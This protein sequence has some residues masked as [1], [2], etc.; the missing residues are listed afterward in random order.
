MPKPAKPPFFDGKDTSVA[1]VKAWIFSVREY[2]E[3]SEIEEGK[4]TRYAAGYLTDTAKTWYINTYA[5]VTPLPDL[6][7]FLNEFKRFYLKTSN[8]NDAADHIESI[9]QGKMSVSEYSTEFKMHLSEL[10]T[11]TDPR[12]VKRHFLRGLRPKLHI[13]LAPHIADVN[14]LNRLITMAQDTHDALALAGAY[15]QFT[16]RTISS[17]LSGGSQPRTSGSNTT[18]RSSTPA[19]STSGTSRKPITDSERA[20]LRA[21]NGCFWCRKINAGHMSNSCPE[22]L[23]WKAAK[24]K[25]SGVEKAKATVSEIAVVSSESDSESDYPVPSIVLETEIQG[26]IAE[27]SLIDCGATV[28]LVDSNFVRNRHLRTYTSHPIRIHQAL[29]PKG[30]IVNTALLSKIRIPSKN[31][32]SIKPAKFIVTPLEHHNVILG[33]PFL[34]A[35]RI[36]ID[37]AAGDILPP[38]PFECNAVS[39][40]RLGEERIDERD[41]SRKV[42]PPRDLSEVSR[43][44]VQTKLPSMKSVDEDKPTISL[45]EATELNARFMK[46]YSDVFTNKLPNKPTHPKAPRH[47]IIL[48][49]PNKS[50][51]G[52]LFSLPE[53]YLNSMLDFI[54]EQLE[55]KRIRPS[56]SNMAA[57]TWMIPKKDLNVMPRV[58]HDYR[59]LNENT[60]KDHTPL[61]RQEDIIR[62][63]A[64]A[65]IRGKLDMPMSYYQIG[66]HP[67]DVY[68]TAFK[69]PFGMFEW[70]VMPQGLCNA[71]ATFQRYLNWVLR[72]YVGRFCAVYIDDIAIWSNSIEE[73]IEHVRLILDALREHGIWVSK[74]K[75]IL[76]ADALPF[77]GFIVSSKGVEV[78]QD[79]I[80]KI[81]S[82]HVPKSSHDIKAFNGL[83]NYIGQFIP[84]LSHWSTVL[85]ALTRKNTIFKWESH[86]QEAFDNIKRLT[87]STPICKP[88][89]RSSTD[90]VMVVADASNRAIGGYY[91]Q[92][93]DYKTMQPAGFH[94]RALKPA[95]KNYPTHDKEMLAIV[96][97]LKRWEPQ[98]SGLHFEV[99]TDHAPLTHWKTQRDLSPRQ[100]RWNETLSRFDFDIHHIPGIA[101]SAADA[102]SRYP[103]T[104]LG[105]VSAITSIAIDA[106]ILQSVK[107]AYVD[108]KL[109]GPVISNPEHYPAYT[110]VDEALYFED[111]LCIPISDRKTRETLLLLHH[112]V[113]NH[114]GRRKTR[115]SI[116]REYFWPGLDQDVEEYIRTCDSCARNKTSTQAPA[117]LLHPLPVPSS[118]FDELAL[119]FVGPLPESGGFDMILGMTDRLTNYT[120]LEPVHSTAT[121]EDIADV[122]YRSW[123]RQFGMPKAITS[124][125]DKLFT[126]KFWKELFKKSK[127]Q[128]RMS[129][130]YHP[131]TDGA[132]ERSN[133]TLIEALRHYVNVRQSDW[134]KHLMH[135]EIVMNN[136]VNTTTGKAPNELLYGTTVRLFPAIN[137]SSTNVPAVAN[138][139][140][141]VQESIAIARDNHTV[142][143]TKQTTNANKHRREE[144]DYKVGDQVYLNTKN[145]RLLIKRKGRSAKFYPRYVGPFPIIK[146]KPETST[147]KLRLPREYK[148]HPTFHAKLLKPAFQNDPLLFSKRHVT[149]PPPIDADNDEW[150]VECLLD[151]RKYRRQNQFLVR[152]VGYP[153]Y[154]DSWE[155]EHNVSDDLKVE[156]WQIIGKEE[157]QELKN[158]K[159]TGRSNITKNHPRGG[160]SA[161]TRMT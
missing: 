64:R 18:M 109:F 74:D 6:D 53:R 128:L 65:K 73:H 111:R 123:C 98:L 46:E 20:Y 30:F 69:T 126:S 132:S 115:S 151:H 142:A 141:K 8:E 41:G 155:P 103:Y 11:G 138:Y 67:D 81:L 136:S 32:E 86:H 25:A 93:K 89:N 129:T 146:A 57:G 107:K 124:D 62:P 148:I 14:D 156:Y 63:M 47:R 68:K 39:T 23:T 54:D 118:R 10:G 71:P 144:P 94:S 159:C 2:V 88:I 15:D 101:N 22:F 82:A 160:R 85:S 96:D 27:D 114:F 37:P 84:A 19:A 26:S 24:D 36:R 43:P 17:S 33:M 75:S 92:G 110:L 147:Y 105:T 139:I 152:W 83:V 154:P 79:K 76:F 106:A 158:K 121:A 5:S 102:L 4:Q 38:A 134:A 3:L 113:E 143:K 44:L 97:C 35:E 9:K 120:K 72:K 95:E 133:K 49:D 28:N 13:A 50:I 70:L 16:S 108:D 127:V 130:A 149:P 145:L 12:W 135:V 51:N 61:P 40:Q 55:A 42:L 34:A 58:V 21:N 140:E 117:G 52:R 153:K 131:E 122:V 91:G 137:P 80:D 45:S 60:V 66:M 90:S 125:R 112:D 87:E 119:D 99:L 59:Q 104:Q 1:T 31:W 150:E 116:A 56:S 161:R 7:T 77:L 29:S 157:E 100:I 78:A 48:K